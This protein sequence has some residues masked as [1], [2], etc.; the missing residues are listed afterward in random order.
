M[1][2]KG[3]NPG[4]KAQYAAYKAK[5]SATKN[6][7]H[8]LLKHLK[9]HPN[10]AQ[11]LEAQKKGVGYRRKNPIAKNGWVTEEVRD[12][13]KKYS[14][15]FQD[16]TLSYKELST[17]GKENSMKVAQAVK[18]MKKAANLPPVFNKGKVTAYYLNKFN[19]A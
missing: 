18:L 19:K 15:V 2:K 8:K 4:A 1:A 17:M 6:K 16:F 7:T 14:L 10:D 13:V 9:K 3:S 5:D 11:A 12:F